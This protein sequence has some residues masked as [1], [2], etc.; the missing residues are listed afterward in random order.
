MSHVVQKDFQYVDQQGVLRRGTCKT[1]DTSYP[2]YEEDAQFLQLKEYG[3]RLE[4][5]TRA[6]YGD[7]SLYR[8]VI[9]DYVRA[10]YSLGMSEE[11]AINRLNL[12]DDIALE[13][14]SSD[15]ERL[16]AFYYN[17]TNDS[18]TLFTPYK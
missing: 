1:I 14:L 5:L 12:N 11:N 18:Y 10:G 8:I 15:P 9:N 2:E 16:R 4:R 13:N 7:L 3:A 6:T 17:E